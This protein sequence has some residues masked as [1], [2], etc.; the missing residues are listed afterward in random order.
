V[1]FLRDTGSSVSIVKQI[2]VK[3]HEYVDQETTVLLADRCVRRL[4]NAIVQVKMPGYEGPLKVCVMA[5]PVSE[6]VIGNDIYSKQ[7]DISERE[8]ELNDEAN[9]VPIATLVFENHLVHKP[10]VTLPVRIKYLVKLIL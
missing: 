3:P 4:P 10:L 5:D 9:I 1:R 8:S 6:F 7:N 2:Y